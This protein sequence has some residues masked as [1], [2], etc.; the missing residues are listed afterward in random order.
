MIQTSP[1]LSYTP[2]PHFLPF[3]QRSQRF[4][5]IVAHRRSGKTVAS[6]NEMVIRALYT[7]KQHA[8]FGYIAPFRQQAKNVAWLYL[9]EAAAP[10]T[11]SPKDIR[12]SDLTVRLANNAWIT[13]YG[14]DNPDALR[15]QYFDGL[16]VDE[17]ADCKPNLYEE[18]LLP[19]LSDRQGWVVF[20]GT[21]RGKSNAFY[22]TN[23]IAK[24]H[25]DTW[26]QFTLKASQSGILPPTELQAMRL[27]MSEDKFNQE[28]EC[29]FDAAVLGT[30][31]AALIEQLEKNG[32]TAKTNLYDPTRPVFTACDLGFTDS[33]AFWFWQIAPD[34]IAIIDHYENDSQPLQHYLDNLNDRPYQ[35]E[36]IY[37]PHDARAKTLQ[38][39][40]STIEQTLEFFK[41]NR[42]DTQ[43]RIAPQL[44]LQHGIDALRL[45]LPKCYFDRNTSQGL[46]HLRAYRRRFD[47][48]T[49][50]FS[51][52]PVH[53]FSSHT[54]DAARYMALVLRETTQIT[55]NHPTIHGINQS[56]RPQL[57]QPV[58]MTFKGL[59]QDKRFNTPRGY[60]KLR[61]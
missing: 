16:I 14:S 9:K 30:Y 23:E 54:S 52:K 47:P 1:Q 7:P 36:T 26:Y 5:S 50:A 2:R 27:Q 34:G 49:R 46:E 51:N 42:P 21:P 58:K 55:A 28:M 41:D 13:L 45:V 32:Q 8:R 61:I 39:G 25:P 43:I 56:D 4:S 11:R 33:T 35:Y 53:D 38:T 22:K 19:A 15:G 40:R 44:S 20:I 6:V 12:E 57:I 24:Q 48:V 18:V 37:L 29:S 10:F 59:M 31:Y 3:H 17:Y 60:S